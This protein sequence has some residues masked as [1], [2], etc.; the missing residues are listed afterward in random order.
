MGTYLVVTEEESIERQNFTV[1]RRPVTMMHIPADP[2]RSQ[3]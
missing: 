2:S 3:G 1:H